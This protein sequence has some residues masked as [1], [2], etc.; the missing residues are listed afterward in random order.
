[1]LPIPKRKRIFEDE[2]LKLPPED[3]IVV[4]AIQ[5]KGLYLEIQEY[6]KNHDARL[7]HL[8]HF[9]GEDPIGKPCD[10][11]KKYTV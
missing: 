9:E 2:L 1:M 7:Y 6:L 11:S 4:N 10:G 8:E 5:K 3:K